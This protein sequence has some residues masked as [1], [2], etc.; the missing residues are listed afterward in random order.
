MKYGQNS[1]AE[2]QMSTEPREW[3]IEVFYDGACPLCRREIEMLRRWNKK[4]RLRFTDIDIMVLGRRNGMCGLSGARERGKGERIVAVALLDAEEADGP[5]GK[6]LVRCSL[7]V[8]AHVAGKL[9]R[10]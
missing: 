1:E 2:I 3:E 7:N 5:I 10:R 9:S 4:D 6:Q 8:G